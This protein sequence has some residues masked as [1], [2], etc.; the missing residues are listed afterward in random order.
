MVPQQSLRSIVIVE[1]LENHGCTDGSLLSQSDFQ[2]PDV[3]CSKM[4]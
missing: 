3:E 2:D 4:L 1:L